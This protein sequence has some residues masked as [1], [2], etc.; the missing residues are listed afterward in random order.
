MWLTRI[1]RR[2]WHVK[3]YW[4]R[5]LTNKKIVSRRSPRNVW[6]W[7]GRLCIHVGWWD[8]EPVNI[9]RVRCAVLHWR[10][11]RLTINEYSDGYQI[12][13]YCSE[14]GERFFEIDARKPGC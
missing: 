3:V 12:F 9:A 4:S 2:R 6:V 10:R 8:P 1:L 14:C 11:R 5:W 7:L 13:F